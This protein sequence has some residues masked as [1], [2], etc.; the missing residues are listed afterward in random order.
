MTSGTNRNKTDGYNIEE[1]LSI[2]AF[3][4]TFPIIG[5][6]YTRSHGRPWEMKDYYDK[7]SLA[8]D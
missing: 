5:I 8:S 7:Q 4:I 6:T 2:P 3:T 1:A